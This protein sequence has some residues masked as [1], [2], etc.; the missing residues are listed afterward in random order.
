MD[1]FAVQNAKDRSPECDGLL[2]VLCIEG[3]ASVVM[4][5]AAGTA[6]LVALN[7]VFRSFRIDMHAPVAGG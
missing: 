1:S 2:G 7:T 5:R 6:V 3:I 4:E